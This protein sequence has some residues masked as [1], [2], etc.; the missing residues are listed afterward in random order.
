VRTKAD[1]QKYMYSTLDPNLFSSL[2]LYYR[3]DQG[4]AGGTNT[5]ERGLYNSAIN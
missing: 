4:E 1:I 5:N 3:F 2:K